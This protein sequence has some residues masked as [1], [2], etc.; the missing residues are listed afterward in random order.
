MPLE[1]ERKFLVH[2]DLIPE[3]GQTIP[4]VQ[5]YLCAD[6]V[7]TVRV[8]VAGEKAWLTIK[9]G[10]TGI[11]RAEYEY[12]IPVEHAREMLKLS[13]GY[14]VEKVRHLIWENGKKWEV[15]FF[16]G[17]NDGLVLAEVELDAEDEA[18]VLPNW[19]REEVTGDVRYH[20]SY[21]SEHPFTS[22]R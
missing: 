21:L 20:N 11:A 18:V 17:K 1:I 7:R 9:G 2:A 22:W 13:V 14:P 19:I 6:P 8:R 12:A 4:M 10:M 15:D 3:A 5:A 16:S